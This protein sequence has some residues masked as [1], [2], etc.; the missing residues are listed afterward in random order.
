MTEPVPSITNKAEI[1]PAGTRNTERATAILRGTQR[2]L[3]ALNFESVAEV[4][5]GN[6]RRADIMAVG[7]NG[8]IWII[9]IKSC[10]ADFK[11]DQKW[12]E[13][14]DYCDAL[15]FAVSADFPNELLPAE[16]G[17]ILS[18]AYGGELV[19]SPPR[20]PLSAPRRKAVMIALA[21]SAAMRLHAHIDPAVRLDR[22]Y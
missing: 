17:L 8:D 11:A 18:D 6:G 2:L 21:R 19:R 10:T 9:E 12:P 15:L 7:H 13:Y 14:R 4:S 20:H 5:L 16:T 22:E 3:R 1:R